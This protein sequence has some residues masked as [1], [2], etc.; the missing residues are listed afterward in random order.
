MSLALVLD[1]ERKEF[2]GT[3][4]SVRS[5]TPQ[6]RLTQL[7]RAEAVSE[8][9]NRRSSDVALTS[10]PDSEIT[11]VSP[12]VVDVMGFTPDQVVGEKGMRFVQEDDVAGVV[13]W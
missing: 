8:A 7:E 10:T 1:P 11:Y 4:A 2:A 6:S 9:L 13:A 5:P 3:S 12:S